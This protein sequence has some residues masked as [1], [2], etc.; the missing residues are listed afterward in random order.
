MKSN[1]VQIAIEDSEPMLEWDDNWDLEGSPKLSRSS[2]NRTVTFLRNYAERVELSRSMDLDDIELLPSRNGSIALDWRL[3]NQRSFL[4]TFPD[5]G[6]CS[7]FGHDHEDKNRIKGTID[8]TQD[9]EW[10]VDWLAAA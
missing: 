1:V 7:Y 3:P 8:P 10:L 2:W 9:H 4:M 6:Y 5:D